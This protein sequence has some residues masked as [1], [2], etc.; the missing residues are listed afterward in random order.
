MDM[1]RHFAVVI[2]VSCFSLLSNDALNLITSALPRLC[3]GVPCA[4]TDLRS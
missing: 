1:L 2:L 3:P 4:S